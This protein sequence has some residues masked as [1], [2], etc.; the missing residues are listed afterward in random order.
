MN[1]A[2]FLSA[3]VESHPEQTAL[4]FEGRQ[5]SFLSLNNSVNQLATALLEDGIKKGD[6]IGTFTT[7]CIEQVEILFATA[8]TGAI[9]V[10]FNYRLKTDETV[11]VINNSEVETL[12]FEGQYADLINEI[13]SRIPGVKRFICLGK[14]TAWATAYE[15]LIQSG[16]PMEPAIETGKDD[17]AMI[18]YTSG[19]S[20]FP[21]GV[22]YSHGHLMTRTEERRKNLSFFTPGAVIL[23]VVPTYHT[24][25]IQTILSCIRYPLI[26]ALIRQFST[27]LFFE[28]VEKEKVESSLLVPAMIKRIIDHPDIDKYDL[29]S[30]KLITYGTSPISPSV[31][32]KA[33]GKL[34]TVFVQGY[35][36]TE[37]S[38]TMLGALDH[39][40]DGT[41]EENELKLKRLKSAGKP[42]TG[43]EI[44]IVDN[45]ENPLPPGQTGQVLARGPALMTGYW[46]APEATSRTI[47]DG[48]L[49][50][51][52][53]GYLDA[54]GYLF[55]AGRAKDIIIRGG[56]NISPREI[57]NIL[58]THPK[59][60]ESAVIGVPDL[61]WGETVRAVVV[62]KNGAQ[63][64]EVELIDFC[65]E[66]LASF[67]KPTSIVFTDSLP[68]NPVGKLMKRILREQ[69]GK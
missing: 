15:D 46:K 48:W 40:L 8:K 38:I 57:E 41:P 21:K 10:P 69:Q 2:D 56:E 17:L 34:N 30:L 58:D 45:S 52:D 7:S 63:A 1:I 51:G 27:R 28:T 16:S 60:S 14:K 42:M 6:L 54:D 23:L 3:S 49:Y 24:G 9:F 39:I 11:G 36:M 50:T 18:L 19:T 5:V 13:R 67:K 44:R 37:G 33:L 31:L 4:V 20:G 64:T 53:M 59:V 61:E 25:G 12:F 47:K 68:R 55:L 62:L 22:M 35:G 29:S 26:L 65:H 43:V 32:Q 66:K